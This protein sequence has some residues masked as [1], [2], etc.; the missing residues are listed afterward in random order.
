M[1]AEFQEHYRDTYSDPTSSLNRSLTNA[2]ESYDRHLA[3]GP[4]ND[5]VTA[6]NELFLVI[7]SE[8]AWLQDHP[9]AFC[10]WKTHGYAD[11]WLRS[12]RAYGQQF[13]FDRAASARAELDE[14][15]VQT[16]C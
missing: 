10:Y 8:L 2:A 6:L 13:R 11:G 7:D 9:P 15:V 12:L 4:A 1:W 14:R 3:G 16:R 5:A